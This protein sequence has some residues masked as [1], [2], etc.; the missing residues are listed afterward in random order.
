MSKEKEFRKIIEVIPIHVER[1]NRQVKRLLSVQDYDKADLHRNDVDKRE[2]YR[3]R[4]EKIRAYN[5]CINTMIQKERVLQYHNSGFEL[6]VIEEKVEIRKA[7]DFYDITKLAFEEQVE[8][9]RLM[10]KA[11]RDQ[12]FIA[13]IDTS[14]ALIEVKQT[15]EIQ[16]ANEVTNIDLIKHEEPPESTELIL[17]FKIDPVSK[18]K[19]NLNKLAANRFK[20]VGGKLD[21]EEE[22]LIQTIVNKNRY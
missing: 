13:P 3:A 2:Y 14:N 18:L 10:Q 16:E 7:K 20:E 6:E 17:P 21:Q 5:D 22:R 9:L 11:K 15:E 12:N 8:L 19:E 1:Y 4:E